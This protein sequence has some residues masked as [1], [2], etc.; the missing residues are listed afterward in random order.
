[1][2]CLMFSPRLGTA[3]IARF[4]KEAAPVRRNESAP[5]VPGSAGLNQPSDLDRRYTAPLRLS[6]ALQSR[7]PGLHRQ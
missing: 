3:R 4:T 2:K 5:A 7:L 6:P 1:M